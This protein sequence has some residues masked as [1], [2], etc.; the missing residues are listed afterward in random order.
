MVTPSQHRPYGDVEVQKH[1]CV[2]HVQK[3][4]TPR[5]KAARTS[6]KRDKAEAVKKVKELKEKMK[7]V[8]EQYGL[9]RGRR[10]RVAM[11]EIDSGNVR[12]RGKGRGR[13]R[14]RGKGKDKLVGEKEEGEKKLR[15]LQAAL[16]K[17]KVPEGQLFDDAIQYLQVYYGN[18]IRD[19]VGNVEKMTDACWAVMYHSLSTDENPRHYCCPKGEDS[20]CKYQHAL[21][22][23]RDVPTHHI[24]TSSCSSACSGCH[25][26]IPADFEEYLEPQWRS[27]CTPELLKKCQLGATQN[28]NE[29]F[30]KLVWSRC[31]KTEYCNLDTVKSAVGQSTIVFNSG[32]QA[33]V[34]LMDELGIPVGPLCVSHFAA[35]DHNRVKR[36]QSKMD[37]VAK[38]RRQT[39]Q[40][41]DARVEQLHIAEEGTTY[42]AGGF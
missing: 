28:S 1:E 6:F 42:E 40:R 3:R 21:A 11:S 32:R 8:R 33:L 26:T 41:R 36:S 9:G 31:P 39:K 16:D 7:E 24:K 34:K 19:N 17:I 18:A 22:R 13:G 29:S 37:A 30:N 15:V 38:K 14:G 12:G 27:L 23:G 35:K 2:G 10:G 5:V 20:W 25:T 4:V